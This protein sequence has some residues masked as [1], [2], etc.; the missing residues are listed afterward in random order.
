MA[1]AP[2]VANGI[3]KLITV[4]SNYDRANDVAVCVSVCVN[5]LLERLMSPSP[6]S[7]V[8]LASAFS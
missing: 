2:G 8:M 4:K 1:Y 5:R 7:Q 3:S 6:K